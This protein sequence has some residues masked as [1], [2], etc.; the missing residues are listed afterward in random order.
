MFVIAD[1]VASD[2]D[3]VIHVL[4]S[5]TTFSP[6][7]LVLVFLKNHHPFQ[8]NPAGYCSWSPGWREFSGVSPAGRH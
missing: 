6:N 2:N 3:L 8:Y 1:N 7:I 5:K 4:I